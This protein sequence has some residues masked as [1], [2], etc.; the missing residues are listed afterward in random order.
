MN[1]NKQVEFLL[2]MSPGLFLLTKALLSGEQFA[3]VSISNLVPIGPFR[4]F[5]LMSCV[6]GELTI[7]YLATL[8]S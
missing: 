1:G 8:A 3:M 4:R 5:R 6:I 2:W 7:P